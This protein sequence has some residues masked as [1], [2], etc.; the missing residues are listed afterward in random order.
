MAE[1]Q[2]VAEGVVR[3]GTSY[4]NWYVV[5]DQSGVTVV[6][7]G[8]AGYRDQLEPGLQLIGQSLD[9]P[10]DEELARRPMSKKTDSSF[11]YFKGISR[12]AEHLFRPG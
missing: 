7:T 9:D 6:D 3:L 12:R 10:A 8:L 11:L 4:V 1:P 2:Q 5:A